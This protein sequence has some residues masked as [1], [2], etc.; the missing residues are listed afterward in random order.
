MINCDELQ[1][2]EIIR[3]SLEDLEYFR[4]LYDR[5]EPR[6]FRY[7]SKISRTNHEEAEDI[8]Q[9]AFI[10]IWRNLNEFDSSM[11]LSSWLYRIVHNETISYCRKK[12][13]FGK[14]LTL[15]IDDDQMQDLHADL[16]VE[17]DAEHKYLIT[18]EILNQLPLK[19]K[20]CLILKYFEKMS[21][22]EISDILK[23]PEGT[24]AVRINRAK[25]IFKKT[26]E[27]ENISFKR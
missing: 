25:K 21:Y 12:R 3:R 26:A 15:E 4:C 24:V 16:D 27:K 22:E 19:Y 20:E 5:Y 2:K 1:D 6:L 7:I 17:S 14:D 13:S 10:K 18:N 9:E 8:L 11:K 23:I